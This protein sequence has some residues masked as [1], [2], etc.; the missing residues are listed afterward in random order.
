MARF[1][2]KP[3]VNFAHILE[4]ENGLSAGATEAVSPSDAGRGVH[5]SGSPSP[6]YRV[7]I[8]SGG[9]K[10][11]R[12]ATSWE[13]L[14][15]TQSRS[16]RSP[17]GPGPSIVGREI[18]SSVSQSFAGKEQIPRGHLFQTTSFVAVAS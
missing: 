3:V 9:F 10:L 2:A 14:A 1:R 4:I 8:C 5:A 16:G 17:V 7:D 11:A 18:R 13:R 12:Q 15:H 6:S